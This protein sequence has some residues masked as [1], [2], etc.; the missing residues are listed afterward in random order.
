MTV[1]ILL[2]LDN[3]GL[4]FGHADAL[5]GVQALHGVQLQVRSGERVALVGGNGSGKSS[6]LRLMHGLLAPT[7]GSVTC[8][9][10]SQAFVFQRPFVLRASVLRNVALAAWLQGA[11][12]ER[13]AWSRAKAAAATA[14]EQVG[15]SDLAT[16]NA[17]TLSGGQQQR[18]IFARAL[19]TQPS[20]LLL[21]EP[22]AS[23][24]PQAKH[25]VESLMEQAGARGTTVVFASHNMGQV[26][27][28]ATRVVCLDAGEVVADL[29]VHA[30]FSQALPARA[31]QF[32][33]GEVA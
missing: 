5:R 7:Q 1:P 32:L 17:R 4:R 30:F 22:T 25:E 26:K 8:N 16:R 12:W 19:C 13:G 6:L 29:P 10:P 15:L 33:A 9:A 3:A 11:R 31:A 2:S 24:S 27:R 20:L 23:L 28:L 18:L 14:L 21:D